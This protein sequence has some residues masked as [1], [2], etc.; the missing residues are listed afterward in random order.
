MILQKE[1][2]FFQIICRMKLNIL[3]LLFI[4]SLS[5]LKCMENTDNILVKANDIRNKMRKIE[6]IPVYL[7]NLEHHCLQI[8]SQQEKINESIREENKL[9]L[10]NINMIIN[11]FRNIPDL[12]KRI[13]ETSFKEIFDNHL[14]D[15]NEKFNYIDINRSNT[16]RKTP[17]ESKFLEEEQKNIKG[18]CKALTGLDKRIENENLPKNLIP[19]PL[20]NFIKYL[21]EIIEVEINI[22]KID[23]KLHSIE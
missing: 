3:I 4:V 14:K 1:K 21:R 10:E 8:L 13:K 16:T 7:N 9:R 12:I 23:I 20:K 22:N 18:C 15:I 19:I 6:D 11:T 5:P 17:E 2:K